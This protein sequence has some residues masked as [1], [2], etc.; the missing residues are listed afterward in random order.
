MY[1]FILYFVVGGYVPLAQGSDSN[2]SSSDEDDAEFP[3]ELPAPVS[4]DCV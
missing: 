2:S 3:P 1:N 4:W